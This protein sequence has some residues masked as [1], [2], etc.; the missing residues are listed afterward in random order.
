MG[1]GKVRRIVTE[2]TS[3]TE[4]FLA[5]NLPDMAQ[6]IVMPVGMVIMLFIYD[7][8]FGLACIIPII[9]SFCMVFSMMGPKMMED[10]KKY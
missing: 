7:W 2:T 10:M 3:S 9:L 6:A 1:S 4:T 5:H 8:R